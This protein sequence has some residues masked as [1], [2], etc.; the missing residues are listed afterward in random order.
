MYNEIW[1]MHA[2]NSRHWSVIQAI[3]LILALEDE[4][5]KNL[6]SRSGPFCLHN[7]ME[8]RSHLDCDCSNE[9]HIAH[10]FICIFL[11]PFL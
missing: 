1:Y 5:E 9:N 4:T 10:L 6:K 2:D 7:S 3:F 8:I 11:N